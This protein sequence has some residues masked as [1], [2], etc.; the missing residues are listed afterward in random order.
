MPA[1]QPKKWE[2]SRAVI[3]VD[4]G[5]TRIKIGLVDPRGKLLLFNVFPTRLDLGK[6]RVLARI[7]GRLAAFLRQARA[8]GLR[9]EIIGIGAAG[10]IDR[11][12][13]IVLISPNFPD[14]EEVPL[15]PYLTRKLGLPC[16]LDNDAN[17]ITLGEKWIG[18]GRDL[19]NFVCLTLGTGVGSGLILDNRLW[20]G[21]QGLGAEI[22]HMTIRPAGERCG[23]GN[24]GC[25]ETL[26]SATYL[27]KTAS[28]GLLKN[29]S[30]LLARKMACS[31]APLSA[32]V[33][34]ETALQGDRF[35]LSLFKTLGRSLGIASANLVQILGLEGIVLGGGVSKASTIFLPYLMKEFKRRLTLIPSEKIA[36]RISSLGDTSGVL[37]A[38]AVA[39]ERSSLQLPFGR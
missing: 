18:A 23:C 34:F 24:R 12:K 21:S 2:A 4:I 35:C 14:W 19:A 15:G 8:K 13:G 3:G 11:L 36:V 27:V 5:G 31:S 16:F 9:P 7:A 6:S 33:I 39:L 17:A 37:G 1:K 29:A 26:A 25:L 10:L 32:L 38:A 28:K 20:Y 22:G 30:P